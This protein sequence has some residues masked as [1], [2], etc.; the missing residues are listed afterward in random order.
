M[1]ASYKHRLTQ[2]QRSRDLTDIGG[3][4]KMQQSSSARLRF[5]VCAP[6]FVHPL[7]G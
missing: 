5:L 7:A 6:C 4:N 2:W 3:F 1:A